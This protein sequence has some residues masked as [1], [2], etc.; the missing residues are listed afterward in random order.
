MPDPATRP[1]GQPN[2]WAH[3]PLDGAKPAWLKQ[4]QESHQAYE[5]FMTY[6][7]LPPQ[8][9]TISR[10]AEIVGKSFSLFQKW[11]QMWSWVYRVGAYEEH[12]LLLR[13]ESYEADRD[14]MWLE[15]RMVA[16]EAVAVVRAALRDLIEQI[17]P[18]T[19]RLSDKLKPEAL[20]RLLDTATKVQRM[21]VLGQAANAAEAAENAEK[22]ADRWG[23][24]LAQTL[25]QFM[26]EMELTPEQ[27]AQAK[28][29]L[30][31]VLIGQHEA[32]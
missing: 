15:Q 1:T 3:R 20:A 27:Q 26:D 5:A 28:H 4:P 14:R 31:K 9:R 7:T 2:R 22:L 8:E 11:A 24:D 13:L 10:A 16:E 21:A 17:D 32:G 18:E 25:Q 29:A 19:G 12:Y 6:L 30:E 23:D